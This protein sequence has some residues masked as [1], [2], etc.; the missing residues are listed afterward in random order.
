MPYKS[1]SNYFNFNELS[2]SDDLNGSEYRGW[3][4]LSI[5]KFNILKGKSLSDSFINSHYHDLR[6][7]EK[8]FVI[9]KGNVELKSE[10]YKIFLEKYD[11]VDFVSKSQ[12]YQMLCLENATAFMISAKDLETFVGKPIFFSFKKDI[13]ARNLWGGQCIS[14]PYEGRGLTLVLFNLKPGF[15]FED[16]GHANEQITWLTEGL[17]NFHA[18]GKHKTITPDIGVDVGPNHLHGGISSG[19]IGF[20]AFFPKRQE[21]KYTKKETR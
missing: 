4:G 20:D 1:K 10:E 6:E 8:I 9:T 16:K 21:V 11:A 13:E 3:N 2:K 14:R 15:K 18:D 12:K 17:M 7:K 5:I 19:A